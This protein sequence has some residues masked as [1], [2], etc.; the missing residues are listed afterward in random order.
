MVTR[1][2]L[3]APGFQWHAFTT[4]TF[5]AKSKVQHQVWQLSAAQ[6]RHY[7]TE[8]S[9]VAKQALQFL[10]LWEGHKDQRQLQN[11]QMHFVSIC[12]RPNIYWRSIIV[13]NI[14][15]SEAC[16]RLWTF[17]MLA[18]AKWVK[19]HDL[20]WWALK[21]Y[22]KSYLLDN[23]RLQNCSSKHCSKL[24]VR[25]RAESADSFAHSCTHNVSTCP[26]PKPK[27]GQGSA[28]TFLRGRKENL[29]NLFFSS[30]SHIFLF[31][32]LNSICGGWFLASPESAYVD[33]EFHVCWLTS[34][35][36]VESHPWIPCLVAF[37]IH[38]WWPFTFKII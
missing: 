36:L 3:E 35:L 18:T 25:Q 14:E 30:K 17:S 21:S 23:H 9:R 37:S 27:D 20:K 26:I 19:S 33:C 2:A 38:V 1:R 22:M 7:S 16:L 28:A 29:I 31:F 13:S 34:S 15:Q 12:W 24:K 8:V 4:R 6:H 5:Q 10:S 11:C 32:G